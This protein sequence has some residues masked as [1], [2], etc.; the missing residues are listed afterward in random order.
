LAPKPLL[1]SLGRFAPATDSGA[2]GAAGAQ[3]A[4]ESICRLLV[5]L[6]VLPGC[7][8][9]EYGP[10][11]E[12]AEAARADALRSPRTF[13]AVGPLLAVARAGADT[14]ARPLAR[15]A[16]CDAMRVLTALMQ[17]ESQDAFCTERTPPPSGPAAQVAREHGLV[18]ATV[19]LA[20]SP[21]GEDGS[22]T[23]PA[24]CA[25]ELL[26]AMVFDDSD[27]G[28]AVEGAAL[29]NAALSPALVK[30]MM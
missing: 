12:A 25:I 3:R 6:L 22:P 26:G 9:R 17:Q 29:R 2:A 13:D 11:E 20:A 21:Q 23:R 19:E 5:R 27:A 18:Q 24:M 1:I 28:R 4:T 14:A 7:A 16:A 30:A 10:H 8:G 15:G